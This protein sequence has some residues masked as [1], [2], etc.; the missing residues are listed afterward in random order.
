M[1]AGAVASLASLV[2]T[3]VLARLLA[4][5]A[6]GALVQLLSMFFVL[7]MPGTAL[8]V[9]VVRRVSAWELHGEGCRVAPWT[10]RIHRR[11]ATAV[12]AV[13]LVVWA[14]RGLLVGWLSLHDA[15][16][17]VEVIA[18]AGVWV[19]VAADRGLLQARRAYRTLSVSLVLEGSVRTAAMVGLAATG[20]GLGGAT[21]GLLVA[22]L[23]V[24]AHARWGVALTSGGAHIVPDDRPLASDGLVIAEA[25]GTAAVHTTRDLAADILTA[26]ASL[27]LLAVLQ[28]ADVIVLGSSQPAHKGPY[29]AVSVP[30]KA[31]VF[32]AL[33]FA[34][35][36]LPEATIRF[37][38][39]EHALRQLGHAVA[40]LVPP[41]SL[42]LICAAVAPGRFITVF[43]GSRYASSAPAFLMLVV[44]M[45]FLC[46]TVVLTSYLL[47]TGRRWVVVVL[48]AGTLLMVVLVIEAHGSL[49]ATARGDALAQGCLATVLG[50]AFFLMHRPFMLVR[51]RD[52]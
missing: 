44:A 40:V 41:A 21:L 5:A 23:V 26:L 47:G 38:R 19:L 18:A 35:Y 1:V 20:M 34:N 4:S 31:L 7:S 14:L 29:G 33:T 28:N 6:Y 3:V 45:V 50:A 13:T 11:G 32:W 22:E 2:S 51:R 17:L 8:M 27:T 16:G 9:G 39:G 46:L 10:V 52:R 15:T 30:A 43:F 49:T 24:A 48:G 12:V 36:L 37:H 25:A 42:L